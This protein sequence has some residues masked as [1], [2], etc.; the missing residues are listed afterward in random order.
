MPEDS[1]IEAI[2][3]VADVVALRTTEKGQ[4][5]VLLV[6]RRWEP[7]ANLWAL[8]GGHVD[9]G[10]TA[11]TAAARELAEETGVRINEGELLEIRVYDEPDRDP[12]GRY[13]SVVF[14]VFLDPMVPLT[15]GDDAAEAEWQPVPVT[16]ESLAFDHHTILTDTISP[17]RRCQRGPA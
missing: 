15:A 11:R 1:Q 16:E 2:G 8:P 4:L 10:E 13:V 17:L 14:L 3:Y 12:R 6:K 9:H 5:E 7:F